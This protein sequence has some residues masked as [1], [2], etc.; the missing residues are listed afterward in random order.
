MG[1]LPSLPEVAGFNI[2]TLS[3]AEHE[4]LDKDLFMRLYGE[5][6]EILIAQNKEYFD[7]INL[8]KEMEKIM[9]E[10]NFLRCIINDIIST[11]E[12]TLPG[13]AYYADTTEDV[14][15]EVASGQNPNPS[16][17]LARKVIDLHRTVR[18]DLYRRLLKKILDAVKV[19]TCAA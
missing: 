5:L 11:D 19:E 12:Y 15:F 4:L 13:I 17:S 2:F 7:L 10:Q 3:K 16:L 1:S 9:I 14:V 8:S 18:P 6:K